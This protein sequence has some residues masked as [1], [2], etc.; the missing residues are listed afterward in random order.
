MNGPP[1]GP[2]ARAHNRAVGQ[3]LWRLRMIQKRGTNDMAKVLGVTPQE[4]EAF[5]AGDTWAPPAVLLKAAETLGVPLSYFFE[6]PKPDDDTA[7]KNTEK[8]ILAIDEVCLIVRKAND[9][10][11]TVLKDMEY[12]KAQLVPFGEGEKGPDKD[13]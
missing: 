6:Y 13:G 8:F 12:L 2:R 10:M 1:Y 9:S 4:F 7:R 5:E 3:K 11:G